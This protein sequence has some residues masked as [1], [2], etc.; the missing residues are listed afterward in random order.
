MDVANQTHV[1]TASQP[2]TPT[3]EFSLVFY[4]STNGT[5]ITRHGFD[6]E[7]MKVGEIVNET[8]VFDLFTDLKTNQVKQGVRKQKANADAKGESSISLMPERVLFED[9]NF[10]VWHSPS[11]FQTMWFRLRGQKPMS[12]VVHWPSTIFFVDKFG[13][14]LRI[15]T[16]ESNNRPTLDTLTYLTPLGNIYPTH[17]ICQGS[18][19]LPNVKTNQNI[20]EMEDTVYASGFDGYHRTNMFLDEEFNE[21]PVK[22]WKVKAESEEQVLP[23]KELTPFKTLREILENRADDKFFTK[24]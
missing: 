17:L 5:L 16:V 22:Y 15:F 11:R 9:E 1:P 6:G 3:P 13:R 12:Y 18:A 20:V 10:I 4:S 23:K 8:Q 19:P 24:Y 21:N 7:E 14:S 2:H